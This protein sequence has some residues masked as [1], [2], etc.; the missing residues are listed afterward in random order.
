MFGRYFHSIST[1]APILYW[2]VALRSLNTELQER[3]LNTCNDITKTT[4]NRKADHLLN[5]IIIRVQSEAKA[6][7]NT[8]QKQD[9]EIRSLGS[10]FCNTVFTKAM[11]KRTCISLAGSP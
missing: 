11:G 7:N 8:L 5:N 6:V 10:P 9:G 4:C 2:Q 3:L 1:H